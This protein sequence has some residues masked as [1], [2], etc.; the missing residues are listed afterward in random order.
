MLDDRI[1]HHPPADP[2]FLKGEDTGND[3]L[4]VC[5]RSRGVA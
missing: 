1:V 5:A 4:P 2:L 3:E